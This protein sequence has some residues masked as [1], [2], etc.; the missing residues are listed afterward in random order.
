VGT[1]EA[2]K[3]SLGGDIMTVSIKDG[4]VDISNIIKKVP[5]VKEVKKQDSTYRIKVEEG[6]ET[7]PTVLDAIR[8]EGHTVTRLSLT[9]PTLDEVYLEYTG[10]SMR[11]EEESKEAAF[12]Q[13]ATMRRARGQ[14][15][16]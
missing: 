13:R 1:P 7:A 4:N 5:R 16:R 12:R 3:E 15:G 2:L 6:E 14:G 8:A 9:K 10:R 11:E